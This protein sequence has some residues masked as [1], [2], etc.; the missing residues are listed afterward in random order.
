[1]HQ[2]SQGITQLLVCCFFFCCLTVDAQLPVLTSDDCNRINTPLDLDLSA[3]ITGANEYKFKIKNLELGLT[4]SIIKQIHTFY[5]DEIPTISRYNCNYEVSVSMDQGLGY[6]DYGAVCNPSSEAIVTQLR[7][8]DC[9]KHLTYPYLNTA[10]YAS[11]ITADS[12]DFQIRKAG[13]LNLVE[14]IFGQPA[15]SFSLSMASSSFQKFNQEYEI[16]VRT[17]QGSI[18]QP[19]GEWCSIY[20]PPI[21][22]KLIDE[23]CGRHISEDI[24]PFTLSL[25]ANISTGDSWDFQIRNIEDTNHF[26]NI[27]DRPN[28]VFQ[29]IMAEDELFRLYNREYQIRVRTLQEGVIQP[30][31]AW[32]SIFTP[33]PLSKSL[34]PDLTSV[35]SAGRTLH[36]SSANSNLYILN[37]IGETI[38]ET[39]KLY[40]GPGN[41]NILTGV[42]ILNQGF[43]QPTRWSV[44]KVPP[45][46]P[47]DKSI[48]L[49]AAEANIQ[50]FP[51][52]YSE[53]LTVVLESDSMNHLNLKISNL[54][55]K[56]IESIFIDKQKLDIKLDYLIPGTYHFRFYDSNNVLIETKKV[57]KS[58]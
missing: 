57:I 1:M 39:Y 11:Q 51:N 13:S 26:E 25:Y 4:D 35:S 36:N 7:N 19:W 40:P 17:T 10:V 49:D 29:L 16:R 32:C 38:T 27:F 52:P 33:F 46:I 2:Y 9:G 45:K 47:A 6:G 20:T 24:D 54:Q 31:G 5:L 53:K 18:L 34:F 12:W 50:L 21:I 23:D 14:D 41:V 37:N 56:H 58:Y 48:N 44:S 22:A 8:I 42:K 28:N 3:N 43:E 15:G 55:G 30:W